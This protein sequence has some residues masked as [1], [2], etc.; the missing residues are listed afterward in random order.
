MA[1]FEIED[2]GPGMSEAELARVFEPFERGSAAG[3]N[4]TAGTGLGLTISRML[5][6]LMGGELTVRSSPGAG[7]CFVVK[8]YLPE[9]RARAPANANGR[10]SRG[11]SPTPARAC[12]C[13][14]WTTRKTTAAC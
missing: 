14:W 12:A 6:G 2:T 4:A 9:L 1:R 5:T 7:G 11:P 8:L 13:W 3:G 10:A